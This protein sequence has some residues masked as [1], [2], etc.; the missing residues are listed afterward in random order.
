MAAAA[1]AAALAAAAAAREGAVAVATAAAAVVGSAALARRTTE[2][3]VQALGM[4]L[5]P[6]GSA[7]APTAKVRPPAR[8]PRTRTR[9]GGS[10]S[11]TRRVSSPMAV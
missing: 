1:G 11:H 9:C 3:S 4:G 6:A 10:V 8:Q 7:Q 5:C 2:L